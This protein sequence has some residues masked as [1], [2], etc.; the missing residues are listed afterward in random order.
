MR[1]DKPGAIGSDVPTLLQRL[2]ISADQWLEQVKHLNQRFASCAGKVAKMQAFA[3]KRVRH[4]RKGIRAARDFAS[5]TSASL[6]VGGG[7]QIVGRLVYL[8]SVK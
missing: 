1:V 5:S 8:V 4:W 2:G 3:Q 6:K 7:S